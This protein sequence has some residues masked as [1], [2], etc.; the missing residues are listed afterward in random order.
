VK[1]AKFSFED[2]EVWQKAVEFANRVIQ[3]AEK[4]HTDRKH[5]RLIEQLEAASTSVALNIAE[6]K[7]RYSRKEF[8]QFLYI[9]RGSLYETIT[10][11]II[12]RKNKWIDDNQ[13]EELKAFGDEIGKMLSSLINAIKIAHSK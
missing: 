7:G 10:L 9:A 11:L 4:I 12:F 5:F 3:L 1:K 8:I 13:L 6:G 2:L